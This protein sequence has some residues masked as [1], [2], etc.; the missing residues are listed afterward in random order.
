LEG[1]VRVDQD[2]EEANEA[3][4]DVNVQPQARPAQRANVL[5]HAGTL[6]DRVELRRDGEG[7]SDVAK[8]NP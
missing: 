5:R 8:E 3:Q 1:K 4:R 6:H 7:Q 2:G